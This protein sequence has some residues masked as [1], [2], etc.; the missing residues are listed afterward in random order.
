MAADCAGKVRAGISIW[1]SPTTWLKCRW[2]PHSRF[3]FESD[4]YN[5]PVGLALVDERCSYSILKL[6]YPAP[7]SY[8]KEAC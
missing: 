7:V 2:S 8:L 1:A 4:T 5:D 3:L 6:Q